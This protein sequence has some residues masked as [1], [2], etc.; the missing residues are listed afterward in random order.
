[1]SESQPAALS[2]G[3]DASGTAGAHALFRVR[4]TMRNYAWGSL[5]GI[6]ELLGREP[7]GRPQAELW[8]GAHP[9]DPAIV[10]GVRLDALLADRPG[11]A[12]LADRPGLAGG[13][14]PFLMKV[15]AAGRPLSLQVHPT[16]EQAAIGYAREEA[17]GIGA[18]DPRRSYADLEHKPEMIVAITP[19]LT[20]CGFRSPSAAADDLAELIGAPSGLAAELL[21]LLRGPEEPA[22]LRAALRLVLSGRPKV[23]ELVATVVAA[24]QEHQGTYADTVRR[25]GDYGDDPGVLA[26]ALLNRVE[27]APGE[28]LYLETGNIHAYLSGLGIEA[29]APSDNVLR[30]GLT[31]KHIDVDGL[32]EIVQFAPMR[33]AFVPMETSQ[34]DGVRLDSYWPPADEFSVHRVVATSGPRELA[35]IGPAMLIVTAGTL[36]VA[37]DGELLTLHR[38]DSAFHAAGSTL[39]VRAVDGPADAYLTTVGRSLG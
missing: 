4:P 32:F 5:T 15:L 11:L 1:M 12:R 6:P 17:Q 34:A 21:G 28:A 26:I 9:A 27:L 18:G 2:R 39:T 30:G 37:A 35:L 33:P 31:P 19:F 13:S 36:E 16:R 8:L 23:R 38:G 20:L 29:M 7:D 22:A 24:A 25:A 10:D 3:P 14:L